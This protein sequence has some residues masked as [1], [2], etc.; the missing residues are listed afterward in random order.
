MISP[1]LIIPIV[2]SF[3][4][5]LFLT[6]F[7]IK[8]AHQIGLVWKDMNKISGQ[9]VAGSGGIIVLLSFI[10]SVFIF[11]A[12]RTFYLKDT[13]NLIEIIA[14]AS[15]VLLAAG[16]G[17]VDD[18]F[19]W[20]HGG[21]SRRSRIIL[22]VFA[23][24]PLMAINA[25]RH[26]M[27]FPFSG[28]VDL[29][30]FYPLIL[31]PLGIV[32]AASTFNFLAGHNGLESGQ[33][34]IILLAL[35]IATYLSGSSWLSIIALSMVFALLAFLFY[36]SCP[37]KV[38]PGDVLT[39]SVGSLIAIIAILGNIEKIVA[40]FFIPYIIETILKLRGGLTKQSF[41]KPQK[42]GSLDMLYPKIY[43]LEHVAIYLMK[44]AGAKPTEKRVVY[45][46]WVFQ[47]LIVVLGF[48]IFGKGTF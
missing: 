25:G 28:P 14:L 43:G 33:G 46:I 4:I 41:G 48:I 19:G 38:F 16:I 27:S 7:W 47:A 45:S 42:D 3:F 24:I 6:P 11:V 23:S 13:S 29:G 1:V 34:A 15:V 37:A 31:I 40:F 32:G 35:A 21:L 18:L 39:Y 8:K 20:Q 17:L 9:K 22:L 26:T 10:I 36:N 30:I 5:V 44:K 12:Y 2:A